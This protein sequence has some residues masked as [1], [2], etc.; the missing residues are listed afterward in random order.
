MPEVLE[1]SVWRKGAGETSESYSPIF[2]HLNWQIQEI[3]VL[4]L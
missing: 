4:I 2:E 1:V 3:C